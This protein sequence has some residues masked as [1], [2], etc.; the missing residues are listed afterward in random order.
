[1]MPQFAEP[2]WL[3]A[4]LAAAAILLVLF[5]LSERRAWKRLESFAA[6]SLLDPLTASHSRKRLWVK[7]TLL[8]LSVFLL[9]LSLA[10]PQ[11]G[12]NWEKAETRGID[13]MIALDTSRS[14][15]AEDIRPNRL[16]RSKLAI[17]DLLESVKGDRVGLIAFAGN[18]FLQCPLT[19]DYQAF[20]QTLFSV[21]TE[22]IPVGGTDVAT[23]I[24]EAEAY[25]EE[26][27]NER[28]LILITDGE[29]LEASGIQ[30]AREA[31]ANGTRIL[32]V[33]VGSTA[34]ELIPVRGP[35]N[36]QDF[37]RDASGNPVS[38][39]L[40]EGTL[41]RIADASEG[42]YAPLGPT[43]EGLRRVYEFSL[44]QSEST[45]REEMLQRIPIERFQWPLA[46]AILVL[47]MESLLSTRRRARATS[48]GAG[49]SLAMLGLST[50]VL[51]PHP[52]EASLARD[53]E[54]AYQDGRYEESLTL[55]RDAL[56]ELEQDDPKLIYNT[57]V[58]AYRAGDYEE[59]ITR[60]EQALKE[61]SPKIR[62]KALY[63]AGNSR[64]A[65][66]F[67]QLDEQPALTRDQWQ[68]ALDDYQNALALDPDHSPSRQNM[69]ALRTAIADH[70]YRLEVN[71]DP[72]QAGTVSPGGEVFHKVPVQLEAAANE[73]WL[74]TEWTGENIGEEIDDATQAKTTIRP[75][76]DRSVTARFVK[77]W[78]LEVLSEDPGMGSAEKSGTYRE[79]EPV[80]VKA[81]AED[82]F[83]FS[84]WIP[85]GCEVADPAAAESEVTL[86]AD[87]SIT[88]TFVP[89]FKLSVVLDPEIGGKAGPSGFFEEYSVV[90]IT[91]EPRPGFEWT[92]WVGDGI[93]DGKAQETSISL[94]ADRLA[95]A[96]MKRIWNLVIIPVPEEGGTVEGA[97]NH[98]IGST[99][100]ISATPAEGFEFEGW[101]GL[102]VEDPASPNT[103]V[104]VQSNEHTLYARFAQDD[105]DQDQ[106][107][108]QQ[109]DQQDQQNEDQQNRDQQ[110]QQQ[111]NQEEQEQSGEPQQQEEQEEQQSE[112]ESA[113]QPEQEPME[114]ATP[115]EMTREEARQLLNALSEDERFLPASELS[116]E[117]EAT[118]S[119]PSGRDW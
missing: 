100:D 47:V 76:G 79:D 62:L 48:K 34:G 58:S 83:A 70:T 102:G 77:T 103:R 49:A 115:M 94:T 24:D 119:Q 89:A 1:M 73:G 52:S 40:D 46:L 82:Y 112:Q 54:K 41:R 32:A 98:A 106:D 15:M 99:V 92:G 35:D 61:S 97:G 96:E 87:A 111:E 57:G 42:L 51:L 116:Q 81:E 68:F 4:G 44:S 33:G 53:A 27:G 117:K 37:L 118:Q 67:E 56:M 110:D 26:T 17:L 59:A 12:A 31:G 86:S 65:M 43:G 55:Y 2:L 66:G 84:K 3:L 80:P 39:A 29:D 21:N 7:N 109:Q 36:Q 74:F 101:E 18:A 107:Q 11:W 71:A 19:L 75:A 10:R 16:E 13:V 9:F 6:P 25:F 64:V 69:E 60:F 104:T 91:A 45:E 95:I 28:I 85:D 20:R 108:D 50:F 30:R 78:R 8:L 23:A 114:Q 22:T 72:A 90:P 14:M 63:N 88:A 38:T 113:G 93:K 5:V 105:S